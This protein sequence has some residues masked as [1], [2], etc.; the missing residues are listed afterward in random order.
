MS[1][2]LE[3]AE[4][5]GILVGGH[6]FNN[7]RFADTIALLAN[8]NA[9]LQA[10]LDSVNQTGATFGMIISERKT[11]VMCTARMHEYLNIQLN[12]QELEKVKDLLTLAP[13]S[14]TKIHRT[15][16]PAT[17]LRNSLLP[18]LRKLATTF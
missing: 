5:I 6:L 1:R 4:G 17:A 10:L 12:G 13:C 15:L 7:L 9:N 11:K 2:A 16:T 3:R 8:S 18:G 14:V